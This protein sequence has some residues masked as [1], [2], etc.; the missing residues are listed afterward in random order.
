MI[1]AGRD[2]EGRAM[3]MEGAQG[4]VTHGAFSEALLKHMRVRERPADRR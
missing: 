1:V 2:S 4:A 3:S